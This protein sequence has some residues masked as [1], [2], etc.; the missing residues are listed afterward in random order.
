MSIVGDH[1]GQST[2]GDAP[3]SAWFPRHGHEVA[4]L[5]DVEEVEQSRLLH[6]ILETL[7]LEI[8]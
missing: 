4:E 8:N 3:L 1:V 6:F 5:K 2:D 7:N